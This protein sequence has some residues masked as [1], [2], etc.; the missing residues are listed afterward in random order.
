MVLIPGL[1]T[2]AKGAA[3]WISL[4]PIVSAQR[5]RQVGLA[6]FSR[7]LCC[8]AEGNLH[9]FRILDG[10]PRLYEHHRP[11]ADGSASFGSTVICAGMMVLTLWVGGARW[12][13]MGFL[14]CTGW[15][16]RIGC[17]RRALSN[18]TYYGF[19]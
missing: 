18:E 6:D 9:D 4:G 1:S 19:P 12:L 13:H 10:A 3:R 15:L 8:V 7:L 16:S 11:T 2:V 5:S 17:S 14:M